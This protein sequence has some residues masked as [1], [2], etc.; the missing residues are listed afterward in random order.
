MSRD[1]DLLAINI[2]DD[3][4]AVTVVLHEEA[5]VL[6]LELLDAEAEEEAAAEEEEEAVLGAPQPVRAASREGWSAQGP[7]GTS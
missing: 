2:L 6:L 5:G 1:G 4:G 3:L 7:S